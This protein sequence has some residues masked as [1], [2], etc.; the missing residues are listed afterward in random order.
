M[1][2]LMIK[3]LYVA[4][5][6]RLLLI[7]ALVFN[8][9][10]KFEA[11]GNTYA[12]IL[13]FSIPVTSMAYDERCHWERYA[14]M[15]PYRVEN[16]VWSKYLL[17]YLCAACGIVIII[18]GAVARSLILSDPVDW[19]EMMETGIIMVLG[20]VVIT[21]AGLPIL[22]RFGTEK[23]RL[24]MFLIIAVG[25]GGVVGLMLAFSYGSMRLTAGPI[26]AAMAAAA[27]ITALS[28]RISVVFYRNR[29][30]GR[31]S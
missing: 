18:L 4:R 25:V 17:S 1:K 10:P 14:A 30:D 19:Q 9:I 26:L 31:Y 6:C 13:T 28:F 16:L 22:F 15:L 5:S 24:I 20:M 21:T 29:R 11:L 27:V 23:G 3:D 12:L 8:L 7:L 2:G